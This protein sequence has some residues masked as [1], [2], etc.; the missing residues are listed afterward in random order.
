MK[1]D[2]RP[3]T[4]DLWPALEDLFGKR[5]ACNGCWCMYWRI[6][7]EYR[8]RG[9][10]K[11]EAARRAGAPAVEA[12]PRDRLARRGRRHAR[13]VVR[14]MRHLPIAVAAAS[15]LATSTA[16]AADGWPVRPSF[17]IG[18]AALFPS[19]DGQEI[20][21][22][23]GALHLELSLEIGPVL[24]AGTL[25]HGLSE[26]TLPDH[27][28]LGAKLGYVL[29]QDWAVLPYAS[30]AIGNLSQTALFAFDEGT[31]ASSSGL[32]YE[33]ELGVK[34][35][36]FPQAGLDRVWIYGLALLPTFEVRPPVGSAPL[37]T[38]SAWARGWES[39]P[40]QGDSPTTSGDTRT[41]SEMF[42]DSCSVCCCAEKILRPDGHRTSMVGAEGLGSAGA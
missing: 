2:I 8:E 1:L 38:C 41:D 37:S 10:E 32:A 11:N 28:F 15:V 42:T 17:S 35:P 5:G 18:G 4:P 20:A 34:I 33:L 7:G 23:E 12:H 30:V 25:L 22:T 29:G 9:N 19:K 40:G 24:L 39:D 31:A 36:L 27:S 21:R 26:A 13:P 14:R 16:L 3:L 6:G